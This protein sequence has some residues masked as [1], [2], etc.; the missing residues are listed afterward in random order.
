MPAFNCQKLHRSLE[1]KVVQDFD[2][3][4][5]FDAR[6][7]S[8]YGP[9][10]RS[11]FDAKLFLSVSEPREPVWAEFLLTPFKAVSVPA[12]GSVAAVLIV[13]LQKPT[14]DYFG[15]TFG[16]GGRYLLRDDAWERAYGLRTA[17]NLI[18]PRGAP[19]TSDVARLVGIDAKRRAGET[20]RSRRQSNRAATFEAF[21]VD[22]LRDVV[23]A[24]TGRPADPDRWGSR[25]TGGDA[26]HFSLDRDFDDLGDLCR[27]VERAHAR[28]DYRER[29]GW[30]DHYQPV[31]DPD[32]LSSL[33]DRVI[34]SLRRGEPDGLE[35]APPEIVDWTRVDAFQFHFDTRTKQRRPDLRL[36]DFLAH[37]RSQGALSDLDARFLRTRRIKAVDADGVAVHNWSV[38]R[39]LFGELRAQRTT[40]V[41]DEGE[42]YAVADDFLQ[43]LNRFLADLPAASTKLPAATSGMREQD[44]NRM[45]VAASAGQSILLDRELV[46][47]STKTTSVE[48]CDILTRSRCLV[49]VKRQLGSSDLSHLFAQGSVSA[50]LLQSDRDFCKS[51]Q[52]KVERL[53][54]NRQFSFFYPKPIVT[55]EF[56]VV[57][58]IVADWR[59][60]HLAD[61]LP[62]FSK[63]TLRTTIQ[64]LKSR[65]FRV[66]C[67]PVAVG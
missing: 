52:E 8:T 10:T 12:A 48:V 61:A 51:A 7:V 46:K 40:Y 28:I 57:Y 22:P 56:E 36:S 41:L 3:Y 31:S 54:G 60:R 59:G 25:V 67:L 62:F 66:S 13:R 14:P 4:I 35:L 49:H 30:L 23:G 21:D 34:R 33:T 11:G 58:A 32:E 6:P 42:F 38:W 55:S 27:A 45:A 50:E 20:V 18:Y 53:A 63:I 37:L 17:L 5:D 29:F 2:E 39:C 65:G 9:V 16:M 1:G 24:A 43:G 44:Y 19:P 15:F 64:Q 26:L 47:A